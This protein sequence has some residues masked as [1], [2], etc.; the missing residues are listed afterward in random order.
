M[1]ILLN[2]LTNSN[3]FT[4]T[5]EKRVNCDIVGKQFRNEDDLLIFFEEIVIY[6]YNFLLQYKI[7][8]VIL[9]KL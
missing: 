4:L 7:N 8:P 1:W 3:Y 9:W 6:F 5:Q 2:Y